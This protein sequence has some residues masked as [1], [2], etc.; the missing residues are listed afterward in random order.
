MRR[1]AYS[2][3][4]LTGLMRWRW[5]HVLAVWQQRRRLVLAGILVGLAGTLW[6]NWWQPPLWR[7]TAV[8]HL[9]PFEEMEREGNR[10]LSSMPHH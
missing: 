4:L 7:S 1:T 8:Y 6:L 2:L 3:L 9:P 10:I 5:G